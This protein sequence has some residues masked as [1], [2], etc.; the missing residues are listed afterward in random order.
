M[1]K[2]WFLIFLKSTFLVCNS[3]GVEYY[4]E[5]RTIITENCLAC[6]S[7]G[8]IAGFYPLTNYQEVLSRSSSMYRWVKNREMPPY[9]VKIHKKI[10]KNL[11]VLDDVKRQKLL[12]FLKNPKKGKPALVEKVE[13]NFFDPNSKYKYSFKIDV[14]V[15]IPKR[16]SIYKCI[17]F[18]IK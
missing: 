14:N 12:A 18:Q 3:Y 5:A 11:L 2:L 8:G 16:G 10:N 13:E 15:K 6:H 17:K 7:D 1:S 9:D 4:N